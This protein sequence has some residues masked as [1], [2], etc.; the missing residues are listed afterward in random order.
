MSTDEPVSQRAGIRD[1]DAR[2]SEA[3][4]GGTTAGLHPQIQ[5]ISQGGGITRVLPLRFADSF[6]IGPA[7]DPPGSNIALASDRDR[8]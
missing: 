5:D 3:G 2:A 4:L 6:N 1:N 8:E 7:K